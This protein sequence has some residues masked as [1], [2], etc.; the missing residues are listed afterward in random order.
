ML[1]E[2]RLA[3]G[4]PTVRRAT[5]REEKEGNSMGSEARSRPVVYRAMCCFFNIS[6]ICTEIQP[7][8]VLETIG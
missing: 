5:D 3:P 8:S 1:L 2:L 7:S 4:S 6:L